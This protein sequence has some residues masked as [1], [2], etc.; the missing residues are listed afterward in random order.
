MPQSPDMEVLRKLDEVDDWPGLIKKMIA[1]GV[2]LAKVEYKWRGGISLPKGNDIK[3]L[4]YVVV[5]KLYS[6]ERTWN[7]ARVP[8][9]S[10]LRLNIRS[11]MNNLFKS[12]YTKSGQLREVSLEV[13]DSDGSRRPIDNQVVAGE[14]FEHKTANPEE[15]LI[16]KEAR[17]M[18]RAS[19]EALYAAIEGDDLLE[20][21]FL[22]I[23]DGC[24]RKPRLLAEKLG[25][26][27]KEVYN[28]LKRLDRRVE[29]I[30]SE[31]GGDNG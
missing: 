14:A 8:L 2:W 27:R 16:E 12:L 20:N 4:V 19:I 24:E 17:A 28:A 10:W 23:L 5:K 26:A 9:E 3:D 31:Q 6:G 25:V 13:K 30:A 29:A 11:E 21:I 18:H 1:Y 15:I 22:E 7:P